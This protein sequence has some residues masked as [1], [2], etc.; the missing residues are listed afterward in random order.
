MEIT[1]SCKTQGAY[2]GSLMYVERAEILLDPKE[3]DS[4]N[5]FEAPDSM[6]M[7]KTLILNRKTAKA[8]SR[9][10]SIP[11]PFTNISHLHIRIMSLV[12]T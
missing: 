3:E 6:R 7:V 12:M 10:C 4:V 8:L 11:S 9:G 5:V 2:L 1:A